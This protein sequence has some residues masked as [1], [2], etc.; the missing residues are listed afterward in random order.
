MRKMN[1]AMFMTIDGVVEEP[2]R[3][4]QPYVTDDMTR[5]IDMAL[6]GA[7]AVLLGRRTYEIFAKIWPNQGSEMPMADFLNHT[8]KYVVSSTL[9]ELEWGPATLLKGDLRSEVTRLK[10]MTGKDIQVPGSPTLV[11]SLMREGLLDQLTLTI[12]P[13]GVGKGLRL[14]EGTPDPI[15]L[16]LIDSRSSATGV[17]S[18][19]Y[20]K[21][22]R[23][24]S[25]APK[26]AIPWT[27]TTKK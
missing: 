13:I 12:C 2:Y 20:A 5:G 23:D 27:R 6:K 17:V 16:K 22:E 8:H 26:V 25:G 7:D 18:V 19:T 21:A 1:A 10:G 15:S 24:L 9:Q 14:F 4:S 11:K 3:W